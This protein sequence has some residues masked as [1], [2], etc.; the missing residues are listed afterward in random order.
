LIA[1]AA[2]I[3]AFPVLAVFYCMY[4]RHWKTTL[5]T[6]VFLVFFLVLMPA[7][8]RGFQRN[9]DDLKTWATGMGFNY[10]SNTFAQRTGRAYSYKN[11]S[12]IGLANRLLRPVEANEVDGR[13]VTVNV[14]NL[15][16]QQVNAV[17]VAVGLALCLFYVTSMPP[18]SQ[19]SPQSDAIE[20]AMLVLLILVFSPLSY[21]YFFVW[22][23][24]PLTLAMNS[25]LTAPL[26]SR[27]RTG[28]LVWIVVCVLLLSLAL[29]FPHHWLA[30]AY[31]N[32]FVAALL[33]LAGFGWKLRR[34]R[35]A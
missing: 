34:V 10:Q 16:F 27:E 18:R 4:R 22:L 6:I 32:N 7:P 1:F 28:M 12:L 17:I 14:A 11:Q 29:P 13:P 15:G 5:S 19:R 23:L 2:A 8:W 26:G 35:S 21:Q 24:Y 3:K 31:G 9:L 33:L 25:F 20:C 30:E